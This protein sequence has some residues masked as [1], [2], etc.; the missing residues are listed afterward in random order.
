MLL[1]AAALTLMVQDPPPGEIVVT[2]PAPAR[3]AAALPDP[4]AGHPAAPPERSSVDP[5]VLAYGDTVR[6]RQAAAPHSAPSEGSRF[7]LGEIAQGP[8]WGPSTQ[9][10]SP[11]DRAFAE[12][13]ASGAPHTAGRVSEPLPAEALSDPVRYA[14]RQCRPEVRPASEGVA[15]CFDRIDRAVR[16]E[17]DRRA[18][19][20]RPRTTCTRDETRDED[21]RTS[22][23]SGR[24]VIGTGDPA[25]LERVLGW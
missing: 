21:G 12:S 15:E 23:T 7:S 9:T 16:E 2:A 11:F 22:S 25:E 20:R 8:V 1:I 4:Y 14:A 6:D 10:D 3:A 5:S 18:A 13:R 19:A 17:Q 24:C